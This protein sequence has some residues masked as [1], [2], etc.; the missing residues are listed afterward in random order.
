M[1]GTQYRSVIFF[2]DTNQ[3]AAARSAVHDLEQSGRYKRPIVTEV[4]AAGPVYRAEEY[5]QQYFA[6]HFGLSP[7]QAA[8]ACAI[9]TPAMR[10]AKKP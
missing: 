4:V 10:D 2:H 7:Q 1:S 9:G 5:H 6:R 3:E 8:L